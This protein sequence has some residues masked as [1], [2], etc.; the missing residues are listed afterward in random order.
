MF[1][2]A[3]EKDNNHTDHTRIHRYLQCVLLVC[4]FPA[5]EKLAEEGIDTYMA[6][7]GV[8]KNKVTKKHLQSG[9]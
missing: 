4:K 2:H 6:V 5:Y 3:K 1:E 7:Q 9:T 8:D